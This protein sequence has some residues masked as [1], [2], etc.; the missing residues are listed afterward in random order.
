MGA[1]QQETPRHSVSVAGVILD[2]S[3]TQVLLIQRRDNNRWEPPG[4]VLELDETIEDGLRRE[5][6]EE[7]GIDI[8]VDQLTGAYKNMD[9]G[10]VALVF[11]CTALSEPVSST[12][13]PESERD[14]L[15]ATVEHVVERNSWASS[16]AARA[17]MRANRGRDT[18]PELALRRALHARGW[19]YF[20]NRRPVRTVRRTADIVF[21]GARLA[22]FV[23]GCFWHGCP[24]HHT[25][26]KT[27]AD[28]WAAKVIRNRER[29]AE[30]DRLLTE[31]GWTVLRV[32]EHVQVEEA[33][34]VVEQ[35]LSHAHRGA[36][37]NRRTK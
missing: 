19:R 23:D 31:C 11:R 8:A 29:D 4:G 7:T 13:T 36:V 33:A 30:T 34:V 27:N 32:W 22:V 21:P 12:A 1:E 5:I 18:G 24:D 10:I 20:V 28:F 17:T 15:A 2:A 37:T 35:A 16:P 25:V 14:R 26:A 3:A 9:R 6:K